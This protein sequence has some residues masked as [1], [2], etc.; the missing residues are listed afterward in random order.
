MHF[1]LP[2][3]IAI[4]VFVS[5]PVLAI[6]TPP[7]V[8]GETKSERF[9]RYMAFKKDLL[10]TRLKAEKLTRNIRNLGEI[11]N[12][13]S[14]QLREDLRGAQAVL[15]SLHQYRNSFYDYRPNQ[16]RNSQFDQLTKD[17]ADVKRMDVELGLQ[18]LLFSQKTNL[19]A[20]I[21]D[22]LTRALKKVDEAYNKTKQLLFIRKRVETEYRARIGADSRFEG[23]IS[24]IRARILTQELLLE[25]N[26]L[27]HA[28][29]ML[30]KDEKRAFGK[31]VR[32]ANDHYNPNE[33]LQKAE[34][35]EMRLI[36]I[37]SR[38]E[39]QIKADTVTL[40]AIGRIF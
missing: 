37:Q 13:S 18:L 31:R 30:E 28:L 17:I 6:N 11:E 21:E 2:L 20:E 7:A 15:D 36:Q 12:W 5:T 9:K 3:V 26:G 32:P 14:D 19:H 33:M 38:S 34:A 27:E 4:F 22:T 39:R 1:F 10:Q 23:L 35:I 8:K 16:K 25:I 40:K 24:V 29:K